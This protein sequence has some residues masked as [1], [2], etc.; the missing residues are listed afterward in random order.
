MEEAFLTLELFTMA[1]GFIAVA[2]EKMKKIDK[3]IKF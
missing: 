1:K 3:P 2:H